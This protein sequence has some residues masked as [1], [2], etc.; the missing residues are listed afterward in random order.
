MT[1]KYELLV[2]DMD[3]TILNT[4]VDIM[5]AVNYSLSN[6]GF[7]ERSYEQVRSYVG[8]GARVL[9]TKALGDNA[10][11]EMIEKGVEYF[12][13]YYNVHCKDKTAPYDGIMDLLHKVKDLGYKL[14]V[15]SNK[16]DD[17]VK[18]LVDKYFDNV[19]D[20]SLGERADIEK[21]PAPDMVNLCLKELNVDRNKA[22]YIGDSD[23]DYNTAKNSG[24]DVILVTWGFKDRSF[25]ETFNANNYADKPEDILSFI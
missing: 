10:T 24:L 25:L 14:A 22:I 16:P 11:K 20:F 12:R 15:V 18:I 9:M 4:L 7:S 5:D 2:F 17:A 6:M 23:V 3:G 21:K 13:S 1:K 8:N 19:F